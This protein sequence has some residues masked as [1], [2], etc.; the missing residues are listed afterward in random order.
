MTSRP[1]VQASYKKLQGT[2]SVKPDKLEWIPTPGQA[3]AAPVAIPIGL[4]RS[5]SVPQTRLTYLDLQATP[6]TNPK[7]MMKVFVAQNPP[8]AEPI[9]S[10]F[11]FTS[12]SARA[13]CDT[14]TE[15]IKQ[16]IAERNKPKTVADVLKEGEEG[17]LRNT[18]LQVSLLKQDLELSR[19]FRA[20]VI[21]GKQLT[22]EQFWRARVV[23]SRC[24]V[25]VNGST[26]YELM[27]LK[28]L[29]IEDR[30]MFLRC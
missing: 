1:S 6:V 15:A 2:L 13:D 10:V 25:L 23:S 30:I 19:M 3:S 22:P 11:N 26:Y 17:L 7:V 4:I 18:D 28:R 9:A 8:P 29:S 24:W 12:A 16:A 5:K 14:I 21:E 20:L 27:R